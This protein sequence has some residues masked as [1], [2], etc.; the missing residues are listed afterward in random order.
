M[1]VKPPHAKGSTE[2]DPLT[3][4]REFFE[5]FGGG[6]LPAWDEF[7]HAVSPEYYPAGKVI[8][9]VDEEHPF[10]YVVLRG[11]VKIV[12]S[13]AAGSN[14]L[15][16]LARAGEL[17][18]SI[19]ALA[20]AGLGHFVDQDLLGAGWS[21]GAARGTTDT[22]AVTL[23]QT[24]VGRV[25]FRDV[26]SMMTQHGGAWAVV[27]FN[28]VAHYAMVEEHRARQLLMLTAEDRYR[29]FL[30]RYPDLLGVLP[31]KDIGSYIGVTP[32]GI[33]RIAARVREEARRGS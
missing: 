12:A 23:M 22:K 32:V 7:A 24:L 13:D 6:P 21:A 2:L 27:V 19:Q 9:D 33:S 8:F 3:V 14:H 28:A 11:A 16:G 26:H 5:V 15:V 17:V 4:A 18:A 10:V 1:A 31:Q 30:R 20:P 25:D 29:H